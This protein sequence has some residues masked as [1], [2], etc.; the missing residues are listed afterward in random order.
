MTETKSCIDCKQQFPLDHFQSRGGK[1]KHERLPRCV[2][3]ARDYQRK[4]HQKNRDKRLKRRQERKQEI[5]RWV[6]DYLSSNP[7]VKCGET[8]PVVLEF[9]HLRDKTLIVSRLIAGY[10]L[11]SVKH[12]V[13]K[14]Q[15]MC[16]N[17]H[18]EK[19]AE[20]QGWHIWQIHLERSRKVI[21]VFAGL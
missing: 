19:T 15:V 17:C 12:E 5:R 9:D 11:D 14:C 8:D 13:A 3:C 6:L 4:W 7:C 10:G 1:R 20:E 16:A 18:R 21:D 2:S